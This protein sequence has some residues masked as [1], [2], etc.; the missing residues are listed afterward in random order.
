MR[1]ASQYGLLAIIFGVICIIFAI[2]ATYADSI[3]YSG[4]SWFAFHW[5]DKFG[6]INN[7]PPTTP[8]ISQGHLW[9]ISE[10]NAIFWSYTISIACG[11]Y[12][13]ISTFV[14]EFKREHTL[15]FSVGYI[16]ATFGFMLL[17]LKL[18][19]LSLLVGFVIIMAIRKRNLADSKI[20]AN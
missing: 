6:L 5:L 17:N 11:F 9:T 4:K 8:T 18:G 14:A 20:N 2:V 15:L 3:Y 7:S 16:L 19:V 13:L 12:S 1:R 10:K